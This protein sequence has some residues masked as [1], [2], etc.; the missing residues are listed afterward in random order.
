MKKRLFLL[1][2][3]LLSTACFCQP[4]K[5]VFKPNGNI[6]NEQGDKFTPDEIRT[7]LKNKPLLLD[8]YNS[9]RDKKS[10][11]NF[12]L[13]AGPALIAGDLALG[14]FSDSEYPTALTYI[15]V[16]ALLIAI[17]VKI[18]YRKKI[19]HVAAQYNAQIA[20]NSGFK[21]EQITLCANNNGVGVMLNF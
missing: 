1:L 15:G 6:Y 18:G 3:L 8:E 14:L 11:G 2:A 12:L 20:M 19:R 7:L 10:I 16:P 4:Q 17:P 9:G 5:L 21:I 13:I